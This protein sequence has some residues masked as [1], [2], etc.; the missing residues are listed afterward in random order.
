ME[1]IVGD[2]CVDGVVNGCDLWEIANR[3]TLAT[4]TTDKVVAT[5]GSVNF[6]LRCKWWLG[7][8]AGCLSA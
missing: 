4:G 7:T 2:G 8:Y 5:K 3:E 6:L 1:L